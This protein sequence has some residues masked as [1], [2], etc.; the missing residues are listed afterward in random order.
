V[1]A[2]GLK[3]EVLLAR[4]ALGFGTGLGGYGQTVRSNPTLIG[5]LEEALE[6]MG[7]VDDPLGVR[8]LSRLAIELYFTP[9]AERRARLADEAVEMAERLGDPAALLIALQGRLWA[10]LGPDMPLEERL[11]ATE[12]VVRLAR[13]QGNKEVQYLAQFLLVVGLM[14]KGDLRAADEAVASAQQLAEDLRMPGFLPWVTAYRGM[15]ASLAG[16]YEESDVLTTQALEQAISL[17][18]DPEVTMMIIGGQAVTQRVSRARM[19]EMVQVLKTMADDNPHHPVIRCTLA[20]FGVR[21]GELD[22]AREAID[23]LAADDFGS[24]PRDGNWLMSMWCLGVASAALRDTVHT[25]SL[26][27]RLLPFADRWAR[28]STSICFGPVA[29]AL[30]MMATQLK[31]FE[32][33][34]MHC[35]AAVQATAEQQTASLHLLALREYAVM[36]YRRN[37]PGDDAK[38]IVALDE[39]VDRARALRTPVLEEG[40]VALKARIAA[41]AT[42]GG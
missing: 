6:G 14:E 42:S 24:I 32:D 21:E 40:A 11:D 35:L 12:M 16:R 23:H 9:H 18:L 5:Y 7:T 28:S 10:T 34:E 33:A 39:V 20:L 41:R 15:R 29:T 37:S 30:G 17:Q 25:A 3:D 22:E 13:E 1:L 36:L 27:E 2:R 38:A 8:L 4:A 26:Y 31:R 19:P